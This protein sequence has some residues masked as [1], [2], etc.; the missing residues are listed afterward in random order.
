MSI[1]VF[2]WFSRLSFA[3]VL[4]AGAI[5]LSPTASFADTMHVAEDAFTKADKPGENKGSDKKVEV[6][7]EFEKE[8]TGYARFDL[9]P[10]PSGESN[11]H[12]QTIRVPV[13]VLAN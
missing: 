2:H 4:A 3:A 6:S 10:L 12:P 9:S 13:S 8:R 7:D 1:H 5:A 11:G